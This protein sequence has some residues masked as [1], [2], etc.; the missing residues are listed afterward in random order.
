MFQL[1]ASY[2]SAGLRQPA[3]I[4][5]TTPMNAAITMGRI[6]NAASATTP[7]RLPRASSAFRSIGCTLSGSAVSRSYEGASIRRRSPRL[8]RY[9]SAASFDRTRS[10]SPCSS[11]RSSRLSRMFSFW[12]RKA[13]T[14]VSYRWPSLASS[15][16][17]PIY[18]ESAETTSFASVSPRCG[19]ANVESSTVRP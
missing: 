7:P 17:M 15:I 1:T 10:V 11:S 13:R 3:R 14:R 8:L 9:D 4:I 2:A 6:P 5:A 19:S 12:R 18:S 16:V